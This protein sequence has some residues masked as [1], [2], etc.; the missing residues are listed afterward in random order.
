MADDI[1]FTGR[2]SMYKPWGASTQTGMFNGQAN[3]LNTD[4]N[5]PGVAGEAPGA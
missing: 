1:S 4:A 3:T 5:W 2:L